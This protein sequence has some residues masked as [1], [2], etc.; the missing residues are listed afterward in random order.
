M[1]IDSLNW[2]QNK[3]HKTTSHL[4]LFKKKRKKKLTKNGSTQELHSHAQIQTYI[5]TEIFLNIDAHH[6]VYL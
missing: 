5:K 6:H 4:P 1:R 3:K 2:S